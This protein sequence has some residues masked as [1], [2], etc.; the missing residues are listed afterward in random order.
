MP[1]L[2]LKSRLSTI[3]SFEPVLIVEPFQAIALIL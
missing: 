2:I 3:L 1:F